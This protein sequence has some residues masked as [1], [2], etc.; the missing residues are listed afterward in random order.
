MPGFHHLLIKDNEEVRTITMNR[1]DKR[2]ALCPLLMQELSQAFNEAEDG[3]CR[4]VIL[5]GA[6]PAFCAGLDMEHLTTLHA[7][8]EEEG[9]RDSENVANLLRTLYEFPKPVIAAVNGAAI[10]GGMGLAI[11]SDF[12]LAAPESRFGFTEVKLG[13]VPAIIA[14]FLLR[15]VGEKCTRDLLLTGRMIKA[16]EAYHMGLVTQIVNSDELMDTAYAHAQGLIQN[17]PQAMRE[18]KQLLAMHS[19]RRLDEEIE[20]AIE[21]NAR[22]RSAEDF[23]EG[24][25]AFLQHRKPEWPSLHTKV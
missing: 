17:S 8:T 23:R 5:T 11:L 13:Y 18:V 3:D 7:T 25:Q 20:D 16:Q 24:I 4:V 21:V 2:N 1:P 9:R 12:T 14:S 22:H 10:A 15:Q 6:G 19:K